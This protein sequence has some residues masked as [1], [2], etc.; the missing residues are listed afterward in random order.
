LPDHKI[1]DDAASTLADCCVVIYAHTISK[2][3]ND[4]DRFNMSEDISTD[5]QSAQPEAPQPNNLGK[6]Q[7][8]ADMSKISRMGTEPMLKLILKF[9][10]PAIAGLLVT[11]LYGFVDG[12]FI[13][14]GVGDAGIAA[15][16]VAMPFMVVTMA[17]NTL[18]G[19]GGN[20]VASIR[21][22]EG[23]HEEAEK[24]LGNTV[25]MI[26]ITY[27]L[28]IAICIPLIDPILVLSGS[29]PACYDYAKTYTLIMIVG[30]LASGL[31]GG[32]GN[33]IRTA[34][35]P[36]VQMA[37][38]IVS[39]GLNIVF[40]YFAV[41]VFQWGIAGAAWATVIS[42]II[43]A[44]MTFVFFTRQ[45]STIRFRMRNMRLQ[46][47]MVKEILKL[48]LAGFFMNA[49]MAITSIL[50]N[51]LF[52]YYG[53][54]E[55]ITGT[56]ALAAC[57]AAGR[58]Q[59]LF[60]QVIIGISMA[61]QPIFGYNYGARYLRR[62]KKCFWVSANVGFVG[63]LAVTII[64]ELIPEQLLSLFAM[65]DLTLDFAIWTMRTMM[66]LMPL[67]A[68]GIIAS[69]YFMAT[70]KAFVA[71]ILVLLRQI[72]LLVPALLLCPIVLP[73][74]FG[75]GPTGSIIV[76]YPIV[77]A[78]ST[79]ISVIVALRSLKKLDADI[80]AGKS[81]EDQPQQTQSLPNIPAIS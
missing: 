4:K 49:L 28:L 8:T 13:G 10:L 57:G 56:G 17:L 54:M 76:A 38:M 31:S 51:R 3:Q 74:L 24:S 64:A 30:F 32:I 53:E 69:T 66:I 26:C 73:A 9:S 48:G 72:I 59:N 25:M 23:R 70:G 60:F 14:I 1:I 78:I 18:I 16:S 11:A 44:I 62:V 19:N 12:I 80:A 67:A 5:A 37:F 39:A 7:K 65:S 40:D 45:T 41:L 42:Q 36:N 61:A 22:G 63:L 33:Y 47:Y 15:T 75:I 6:K 21:L 34:G 27:V 58:V 43:A 46:G 55:P 79:T 81:R 35:S 50:L 29:T 68:Y 77:D 71:N 2:N 20:I 52:I